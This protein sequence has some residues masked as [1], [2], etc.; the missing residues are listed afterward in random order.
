M[1]DPANPGGWITTTARNRAIDRIRRAQ[2]LEHKLR[3]LEAL[4]P[5]TSRRTRSR[6]ARFP[7]TG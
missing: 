7:T 3:E 4:V 1:R 6:T 2:R 5:R